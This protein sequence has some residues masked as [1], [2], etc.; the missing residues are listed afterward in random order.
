[1]D[2]GSKCGYAENISVSH[3]GCLIKSCDLCGVGYSMHIVPINTKI[4]TAH[5]GLS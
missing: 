5:N 1:M 3:R 4:D 2:T